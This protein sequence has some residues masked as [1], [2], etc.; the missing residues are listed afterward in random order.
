MRSGAFNYLQ[1]PCDPAL[2][3]SA[4]NPFTLHVV[5][6]DDRTEDILRARS[7]I[8]MLTPREKEVLS[9]MAKGLSNKMIGDSLSIGLRT[10]ETHRFHLMQKMRAISS[11]D[12]IRIAFEAGLV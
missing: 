8:K 7:L 9:A 4:L 6:T 12:A 11:A 3:A 10:V 2:V 1:W 5:D